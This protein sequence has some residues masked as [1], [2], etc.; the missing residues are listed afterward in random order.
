[1]QGISTLTQKG[2]ISIP[3]SI[4]DHFNLKTSD[5]LRFSIAKN[6]I[7]A[8]PVIS[9]ESMFGII[10]TKKVITKKQMKKVV[11]DAVVAKYA[12]NT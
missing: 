5:R 12:R 9:T 6:K 4:R 10:K 8:E 2:Q 7:I 3:K 1:M 11:R